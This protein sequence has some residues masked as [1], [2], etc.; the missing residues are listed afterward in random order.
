MVSIHG[1]IMKHDEMRQDFSPEKNH[2]TTASNLNLTQDPPP[3]IA[4]AIRRNPF[5]PK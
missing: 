1:F 3:D 2:R 4:A 5:L